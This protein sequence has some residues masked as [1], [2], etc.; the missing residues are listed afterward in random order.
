VSVN[1]WR[2]ANAPCN[3]GVYSLD[4]PVIAPDDMLARLAAQGYA[5][6]DSGPIGYF[7]T[8][9]DLANRLAHHG[10]GLAGGWVDL[11]FH[12]AGGFTE[13]LAG[14]DAAL[15]V[16]TAVPVD[17]PRFAPRPTLALPGD[18]CR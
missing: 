17:D 6:V 10:M 16:F 1:E 15:D 12:D 2:V 3:F 14:L 7:G 5:G 13:D 11:R 8:H 9:A 18:P 4:D